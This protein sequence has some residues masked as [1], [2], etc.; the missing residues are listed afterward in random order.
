MINPSALRS[1]LAQHTRFQSQEM[2]D[3]NEL[4]DT[5][6]NCFADSQVCVFVCSVCL[7]VWVRVHAQAATV[8]DGAGAVL[9]C[10]ALS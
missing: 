5:I 9:V 8:V 7:C 4:L 3:A 6:Y 1:A 10:P 2:N